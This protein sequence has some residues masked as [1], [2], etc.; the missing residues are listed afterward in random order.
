[1]D[2]R[3]GT[4]SIFGTIVDAA[5][6]C[7]G[8][9]AGLRGRVRRG[10]AGPPTRPRVRLYNDPQAGFGSGEGAPNDQNVELLVKDPRKADL[11]LTKTDSPDP[12]ETGNTLTYTL[13]V[14]NDGPSAASG[15]TVTDLLP[16][17][18]S[19][20]FATP[21]QGTCSEAAGTVSCDLGYVPDGAVATVA[22][23]VTPTVVGTIVNNASVDANQGDDRPQNDSDTE[24]TVVQA[25]TGYVRPK[26]ATPLLLPL[27]P[28]YKACVAP[29][30]IHGPPLSHAVNESCNP[31]VARVRPADCRD[32]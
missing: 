30:R 6:S 32:R 1:M 3:D 11:A 22:I 19:F 9:G 8:P 25:P 29:N 31:P 23:A 14:H 13:T 16:P 27:T 17:S 28:A 18:V 2:N 15:V 5:S 12:A 7:N 10:E 24:S 21:S 20:D 26:S 4:L